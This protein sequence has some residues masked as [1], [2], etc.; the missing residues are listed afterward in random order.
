MVLVTRTQPLRVPS[1]PRNRHR[2]DASCHAAHRQDLAQ[3]KL[4]VVGGR[5]RPHPHACPALRHRRLRGHPRLRHAQGLGGVPPDRPPRAA[6]PLG[7]ALRDGSGLQRPRAGRRDPRDRGGERGA[8][9]LRAPARR[10]AAPG[11]W[12]SYPGDNPVEVAI[13]VWPW[14]AYLGEEALEHGVRCKVSSF[15]RIGP[16]TLPPAAKATGQYINS[17]LAKLESSRAGYDE[18]ILLNEEGY[19]ADGSGENVFVVRD[20]VLYTPPTTASCLPGITR[21]T[22]IRIAHTLG[23]EVR[24][25]NLVRTDLYFGDE[26]FLCGTAAEVTPVASVDDHETGG[27]GPITKQIQD[28]FFAIVGG[29]DDRFAD[30]L[31]YPVTRRRSSAV[32]T[33]H[34][35]DPARAA[36]PRRARGGAR[37][38][39]AALGQPGLRADGA[40][41][42]ARRSPTASAP[43]T[44]SPARAA[45][46][47]LHVALHR[48]GVGPGDEVIT[49]SFSFVASANV[50]LF[51]R[52]TPVF[53]EIDEHTLNL[54]PAAV[55]AA[56]TA[57]H[58]GHH[59]GAHLRLPVR[60]RGDHGDRRAARPGGDRGRLRGDRLHGRRPRRR[61]ARQ[62]GGVRLLSQ[63]AAHHRRGRR[64]HDRRPR[65]SPASCAASSTRAAPT[66][67]T[68]SCTSG[69]A[70][71]TAWTRCP[72]RSA[73]RQ[74]EKLDTL[75]ERRRHGRRAL[76]RAARRHRRRRAALSRAAPAQLVRLLRALRR[77]HRPRRRD[78]AAW[79]TAGSPP[80]RTCRRS[81][82]SR[83][84]ASASA[85]A[86]G[87]S[88]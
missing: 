34:P 20:G 79:P 35:V 22:V 81:T 83:P 5:K 68:G 17:V 43:S 52:A 16:N 63:Q 80:A 74:L 58:E 69:S 39:R 27:R 76:R 75:L 6:A 77:R 53:A 40:G 33:T 12:A 11:R 64:D 51:E 26:V 14:G 45:R 67:A 31:E 50:I 85:T 41:V 70:S 61:H 24:E 25:V 78:R 3:R 72:P 30:M 59:P 82:S 86:R 1:R 23:Y 47:G 7:L 44:R 88:R 84:I 29:Q 28:M 2:K 37:A 66:T 10:S 4:R 46:P 18:A 13:A 54:D 32:V 36:V 9:V 42:R 8:V 21:S 15:R 56:I 49:S 38:R 87:C 62:P 60:H 57:A 65:R 71:T 55:E 73:W 48:L 19:V